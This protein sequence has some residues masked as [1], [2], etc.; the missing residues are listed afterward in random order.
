[1]ARPLIPPATGGSGAAGDGPVSPL[2]HVSPA[3]RTASARGGSTAPA[4]TGKA[5]RRWVL[6]LLLALGWLIQA[7]LRAWFGRMQVVPLANPDETAYLIAA[8]VLAGGSTADLSYSTLYQGG[9]PLVI[10]PVY[11]FTSDPA[12]VYHAVVAVNSAIG[13]ALLPLGYLACR[14]LGLGRPAAYG[15]AF[16]AALLPDGFIYSQYAMSDAIFPVL[17]LAWLLTTHSWL[18]AVSA[19]GRYAAAAGSALLAGFSYATHSRGLVMLAGYAAVGAFLLWRRP[20]ARASV[21]VAGLT[22]LGTVAAGWALNRYLVSVI[23]PEGTRSLSGRTAE[24]L[25]SAHGAIHV[26]EMAVGQ[27]WRVILDG[28]GIAGI[29]LVAAVA[30]AVRGGTGGWTPPCAGGSA[31]ASPLAGTVRRDVRTDLRIMAGLSVGVSTLIAFIAPAALPPDQPQAWASGRYLDGMIVVFFLAGATVLLRAGLRPVLACAA[32]VTVLFVLS[33]LTVAVYVGSSVPTAGFA[34]GLSFGQ[35]AVLAQNWDQASV[36]LATAVTLGLLA[37]WIALSR[38][39]RRWR[40]ALLVL[41]AGL[42][43]VSLVAV[44][45]ITSHVSRVALTRPQAVAATGLLQATGLKPGEQIAVENDFNWQYWV[46]Q[47][48]EVYWTE[49]EFFDPDTEPP[50]AGVTVV[51]TTWP[52]GQPAQASWPDAPAG[53]HVIA[54]DR[55]GDWVAWRRG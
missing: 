8:R 55:D 45:Q 32:C 20:A 7:G 17:T 19:R 48:F 11:W 41:G 21:A 47:A 23:Y 37:V 42:A 54:S 10:T 25:T 16:V 51:E 13:A 28:W 27:L 34:F 22:A 12:T 33:A 53:W 5:R 4:G 44:A 52:D 2:G 6:V 9:Y 18:T 38:V 24:R 31:G 40:P 14:R 50:P 29:G 30:V 39:A 35:V 49:L 43:A 1:L 36:L 46:P 26:F 15:V 3:G